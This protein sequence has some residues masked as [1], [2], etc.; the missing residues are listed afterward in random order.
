MRPTAAE[1]RRAL[2]DCSPTLPAL[3]SACPPASWTRGAALRRV[4]AR[5]Q[6]PRQP[7]PRHRPG[8]GRAPA[9]A[10]LA[11]GPAAGRCP[12]ALRR[13]STSARAVASPPCR[14]P[15]HGRRSRWTLVDSVG[16]KATILAEIVGGAGPAQRQRHRGSRRGA[17]AI[18]RP[19]RALRPGHCPC[20]RRA[21]GPGRAGPAPAGGRRVAAGLEGPAHRGGRG[22]RRGQAAAG[23]LGGG[24]V[25]I[26]D[27]GVPA[28]GGHRFVIVPK[29]RATEARFPRRPGEPGRRPLG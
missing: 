20:L 7:D 3:P 9:P 1:T 28:L 26:V 19:P 10:R 27:P 17:R 16:K 15:W 22:G 25:E 6:P 23:Q 4:A 13:P 11:R 8:R 24:R 14:W 12:G 29:E 2:E 5:R 21:A 18:R